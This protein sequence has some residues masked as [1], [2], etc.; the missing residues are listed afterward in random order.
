MQDRTKICYTMSTELFTLINL[1]DILPSKKKKLF[2]FQTSFINPSN[3][4]FSNG[5]QNHLLILLEVKKK[6]IKIKSTTRQQSL[7]RICCPGNWL[8]A[9]VPTVHIPRWQLISIDLS[10]KYNKLFNLGGCRV[11]RKEGKA[12]PFELHLCLD[13][14]KYLFGTPWVYNWI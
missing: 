12:S 5:Y 8:L 11:I 1:T 10:F 13:F 3:I 6:S 4:D 7:N 14:P 2:L 9:S